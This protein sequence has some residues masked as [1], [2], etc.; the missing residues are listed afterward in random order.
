MRSLLPFAALA[1]ALVAADKPA[2][3]KGDAKKSDKDRILGTWVL[4]GLEANGEALKTGDLLE[5]VK[6][7]KLT[8]KEDGTVVNSKHPDDKATYKLDPDKKPATLD[9]E[10]TGKNN[11]AMRMIYRLKDDNTLQLCGQKGGE[12]PKEFNSKED[13]M[14]M[15]L[16]REAKKEGK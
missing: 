2:A 12:R 15:T 8:F 5:S 1:I 3:D 13:Q 11:E 10:I 16:T 14:V 7:M 4:T 9:I 6:D